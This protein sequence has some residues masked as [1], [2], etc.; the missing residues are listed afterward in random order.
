M[1][2]KRH[3][4]QA[5]V[6]PSGEWPIMEEP[7]PNTDLRRLLAIRMFELSFASLAGNAPLSMRC[8]PGS[9]TFLSTGADAAG[10]PVEAVEAEATDSEIWTR[11]T[12]SPT[13]CSAQMCDLVPSWHQVQDGYSVR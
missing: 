1:T 13:K 11:V 2:K 5:R 6:S 3:L 12:A 4:R 8:L 7:D 10:S 9:S